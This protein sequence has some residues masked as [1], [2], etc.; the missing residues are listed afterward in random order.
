MNEPGIKNNTEKLPLWVLI[1]SA[2]F[3]VFQI[4]T[5]TWFFPVIF[6]KWLTRSG[7]LEL[8]PPD[9]IVRTRTDFYGIKKL[10]EF[11]YPWEKALPATEYL[12][13][14]SFFS[15]TTLAKLPGQGNVLI[16]KDD[17]II[18][19]GPEGKA[20]WSNKQLSPFVP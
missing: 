6:K 13:R 20:Y 7:Q 17:H 5:V 19:I 1:L 4:I 8:F 12:V 2:L 11:V 15:I 14:I 16:P 3:L 10:Q 9:S 18:I